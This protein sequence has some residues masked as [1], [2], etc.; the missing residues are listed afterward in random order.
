MWSIRQLF[1]QPLKTL[2]GVAL[3][4][5]A[6]AVLCVSLGQSLAAAKMERE[7]ENK[8]VT[9]ALAT[10][11]YQYYEEQAYSE[12][13]QSEYAKRTLH[14][15][16]PEAVTD[17]MLS[18][19]DQYPGIVASV[20]QPGLATAHIPGLT[21]ANYTEFVSTSVGTGTDGTLF[22]IMT[23]TAPFGAPY[24]QIVAQITLTE[25]SEPETYFYV[26]SFN[27]TAAMEPLRRAN[28]LEY[29]SYYESSFTD[30]E[31]AQ[32]QAISV[33]LTGTIDRVLGLQEGYAD[34]T[35]FTARMTL[36]LPNQAALDALELQTGG[37]YLVYG[38]DYYDN[39]WELRNLIFSE[40]YGIV[41]Q[42]FGDSV[43]ATA[44]GSFDPENLHMLDQENIDRYTFSYRYQY[45]G[46]YPPVYQVAYYLHK[47]ENEDGSS[48]TRCINLTNR[49]MLDYRAVSF[50][51]FDLSSLLADVDEPYAVPTIARL[52]GSAEEFLTSDAGTLWQEALTG[53]NISNHS[54]AVIGTEHLNA[55][56][57]FANQSA[58]ISQG[59]GFT[60]EETRDGA[61]VCIISEHLAERNGLAVGDTIPV[62]YLR[63]DR[64]NPYQNFLSDG[65]GITNPGGY[66]YSAEAGF[67]G[68][69][70]E[71]TIVGLYGKDYLWP[72]AAGT[73]YGITP[74][75]IFVPKASVTGDMDY[76]AQGLFYSAVLKNGSQ[77]DF[78]ALMLRQ[79]ENGL[80]IV[81]DQGY[82]EVRDSLHDYQA[83]A[84]QALSLGIIVYAVIMLLYLFLFPGMQGKAL[85]TMGSLGASRKEK[86]RHMTLS[87]LGILVPG[88]AL[89]LA[90]GCLLWQQVVEQLMRSARVVL[91]LEL[92]VGSLILI[93]CAQLALSALL[94]FLVSLPLTREKGMK[95]PAKS[96]RR[97]FSKP[98]RTSRKGWGTV[99][100]AVIIALALC[101]LNAAN[102]SELA[103]Y[104][105]ACHATP[106]KVTLMTTK[107]Q[108]AYDLG[109]FGAITDLFTVERFSRFTPLK[110]LENLQFMCNLNPAYINSRLNTVTM[111]FSGMTSEANP[112]ELS[113]RMECR[114]TWEEGYDYRVFDD[115]ETMYVLLPENHGLSDYA[116][117]TPGFQIMVG[118]TNRVMVGYKDS[119]YGSQQGEPLYEFLCHEVI[120]TAAGTY[121]NSVESNT[122]FCSFQPLQDAASA[123]H[124]SLALDH[125]SATL[126]SNDEAADLR[127]MANQWFAD[128]GDSA[129]FMGK[130]YALDIDT[131]V[132]DNLK[133]ALENSMTINRI[134]TMLV[135][136]LSTGAGFFL[137]FL[138]IRSRKR[139]IILM[140]TLGKPNPW[141]FRDLAWEQMHS[142][143]LGTALGGSVFRWRPLTRLSL[144]VLLYFA[145]LSLALMIFL[146]SRL[147]TTIKEEE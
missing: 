147:L 129:T 57:C 31:L 95:N 33:T 14:L 1:R 76:A 77:A 118:F 124:Q 35:G 81:D 10:D 121:A 7:L 139:E 65:Y 87:T 48:I 128:P 90:F 123:I 44:I 122:V 2:L 69:A 117:D 6:A 15:T 63:Y 97:L 74:N 75:T 114:I 18:L 22:S 68:E 86:L 96:V 5:L 82:A 58:W 38:M 61:R 3:V 126:I 46:E 64:N 88:A 109:A 26:R 105:T 27:G 67:A 110:Y 29:M 71:Y 84:K 106:V 134:C 108:N 13:F 133:A 9:T 132:L 34:P 120:A 25:I 92:D 23:D 93:S 98:P 130:D 89:G 21:A 19:A 78:E 116:P 125:I 145:G 37:Q 55:V 103:D 135:F 8:F 40:A 28:G 115:P 49:D 47:Q 101:G 73:L 140:R 85:A 112:P 17:W 56:A 137:G 43:P 142:I 143:L 146:N 32:A 83:V 53:L 131:G 45:N 54:F 41:S 100:F 72:N 102:E 16:K 60:D 51:L 94:A 52:E 20:Q 113:D 80:F 79:G 127:E 24:T 30:E 104:E 107:T 4:T 66:F 42:E 70:E 99:L 141:I 144:F 111:R 11:K 91:T 138:M 39:D 59:R 136:L 62:Q 50:S 119:S 12:A 36:L